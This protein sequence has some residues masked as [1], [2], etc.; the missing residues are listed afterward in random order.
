MPPPKAPDEGDP[1]S[2]KKENASYTSADQLKMMNALEARRAECGDGGHFKMSTFNDVAALL[3]P[4]AQGAPKTGKSVKNKY[5][6]LKS[7]WDE[8]IKINNNSGW[9]PFD[10]ELGANITPERAS[11]WNDWVAK[12][13]KA[14]PFRNAGF[15]FYDQ[16]NAIIP[17]VSAVSR[18]RHVYRPSES[19]SQNTAQ[20]ADE[21]ES[22]RTSPSPPSPSTASQ[23]GFFPGGE[24]PPWDLSLLQMDPTLPLAPLPEADFALDQLNATFAQG[25]GPLDNPPDGPT[26]SQ[27]DSQPDNPADGGTVSHPLTPPQL[28]IGRKRGP[29]ETPL[30]AA[31]LTE[32]RAKPRDPP[33]HTSAKPA[34][35]KMGQMKE[36]F[37]K[38]DG[39]HG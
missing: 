29:S 37:G 17:L 27:P 32:K 8:V 30:P 15:E 20:D 14:K 33:A 10:K 12:N 7:L 6:T 2:S 1:P 19:Q 3:N 22:T 34:S 13:P 24:S 31:R 28:A 23:P 11:V 16:F 25:N 36:V 26:I 35:S 38:L 39:A 5:G 9:P 4:P 21:D 18:G